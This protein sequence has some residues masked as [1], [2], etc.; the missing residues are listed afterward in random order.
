MK[1]TN[2]PTHA[3]W[4]DLWHKA[5]S[6]ATCEAIPDEIFDN[7]TRHRLIGFLSDQSFESGRA[8]ERKKERQH[9]FCENTT[10]KRVLQ[11]KC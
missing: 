2:T 5:L 4:L 3:Q 6:L 7:Y 9:I 11:T 1:K 8:R 10:R